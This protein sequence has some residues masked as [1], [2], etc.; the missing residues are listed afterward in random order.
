MEE[1]GN[2]PYENFFAVRLVY[3]AMQSVLADT[4]RMVFRSP[5]LLPH[6]LLLP[7][8][9]ACRASSPNLVLLQHMVIPIRRRHAMCGI[10]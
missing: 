7:E 2:D 6:H 10:P 9:A 8:D 3:S 5:L 1:G 4:Q